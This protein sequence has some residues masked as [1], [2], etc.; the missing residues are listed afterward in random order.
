MGAVQRRGNPV[1]LV[2]AL[3]VAAALAIFLVFQAVAGNRTPS[4]NPSLLAC[5]RGSVSV[6]GYVLSPV[7]GDP[8][9]ASHVRSRRH[10]EG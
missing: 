7:R 8:H 2:I 1:R 4:L 6:S 9:A 10:R 3:S 5:H